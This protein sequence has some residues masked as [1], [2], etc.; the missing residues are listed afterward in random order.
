MILPALVLSVALQVHRPGP[1]LCGPS[2]DHF[3]A[4]T[5]P[6]FACIQTDPYCVPHVVPCNA[7]EL[8]L[9]IGLG[10]HESPRRRIVTPQPKGPRRS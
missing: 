1:P 6:Y 7:G 9:I 2:G 3:I 4:G 10:G 5:F 8:A